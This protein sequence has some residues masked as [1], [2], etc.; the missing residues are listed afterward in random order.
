MGSSSSSETKTATQ[1][2]P[3]E[4]TAANAAMLARGQ[5]LA[6][7]GYIPYMGVDVAGINPA[8]R[9]AMENVGQMA[10]AFGLA[11]PTAVDIGMP[12]VTTGGMTGYSAFPIYEGALERFRETRPDQY[13]AYA[14]ALGYDPLTGEKKEL[15]VPVY[16]QPAAQAS[17]GPVSTGMPAGA[18]YFSNGQYYRADGSG[19]GAGSD[20]GAGF[21]GGFGDAPAPSKSG[22]VNKSGFIDAP[23]PSGGFA[24]DMSRLGNKVGNFV[25]SGGLMGAIGRAMSKKD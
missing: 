15:P 2:I 23:Y 18:A 22:Y 21:S 12:E 13:T 20:K 1:T 4:V 3:P 8:E 25:S 14:E 19:I 6:D 17:S 11:A 5:K 7:L 24:S 10:S 16:S 9:A